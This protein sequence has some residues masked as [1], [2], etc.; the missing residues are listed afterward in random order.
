M[1]NSGDK[2]DSMEPDLEGLSDLEILQQLERLNLKPVPGDSAEKAR[3]ALKL[4]HKAS[5]DRAEKQDESDQLAEALGPE[6]ANNPELQRRLRSWIRPWAGSIFGDRYKL[7]E[8]IDEGGMGTVWVAEQLK[9]VRRRVAIKIVK[10]GMDS[11]QVLDRFE[12]ERQALAAMD[13]PNIAKILD[14]GMT[15]VQTP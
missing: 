11:R 7:V 10:A 8:L 15:D 14:G 13:H 2:P 5:K 4:L 12:A 1:G 9:P 6:L 3:E